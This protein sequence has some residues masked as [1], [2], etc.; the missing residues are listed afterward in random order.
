MKKLLNLLTAGILSTTVLT[1]V[2]GSFYN[3]STTNRANSSTP[4]NQLSYQDNVAFNNYI[5]NNTQ[6]LTII[7]QVGKIS[8]DAVFSG[9]DFGLQS[10]SSITGNTADKDTPIGRLSMNGLP[11]STV[12]TPN[13]V[14]RSIV[15]N[16]GKAPIS[17]SFPSKTVKTKTTVSVTNVKNWSLNIDSDTKISF[18]FVKEDLNINFSIDSHHEDSKTT[19][20]DQTLNFDSF[21]LT[22]PA[23]DSEEVDYIVM[24]DKEL[25]NMIFNCQ[26]DLSNTFFDFTDSSGN[27]IQ[28][29]WSDLINSQYSQ[30]FCKL[31]SSQ[32]S[33]SPLFDKGLIEIPKLEDP[34][35][36]PAQWS[37][38]T[39]NI[40]I[41]W[42]LSFTM[43]GYSTYINE[44]PYSI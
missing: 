31:I 6:L 25:F 28:V 7:K 22:I 44:T 40:S 33:Y 37:Y 16:S 30:L 21:S 13:M 3:L 19:I 11:E 20:T 23:N 12:G 29:K 4:N 10:L 39:N 2:V 27:K 26:I 32:V 5:K 18:L 42:P 43:D 17:I 15:T 24:Q 36:D 41:N 34:A 35:V 8:S 38:N 14:S 1:P 9:T